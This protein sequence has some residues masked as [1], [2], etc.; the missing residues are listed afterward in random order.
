[1]AFIITGHHRS[2]TSILALLCK[3]HP[4]IS[5]T[6]E[7]GNFSAVGDPYPEYAKKILRILK[8]LLA[9]KIYKETYL[10]VLIILNNKYY[11][12]Y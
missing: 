10:N 1:M 8:L 3:T 11:A 6:N 12:Y 9:M 2:G 7:F 4:Q 5:L